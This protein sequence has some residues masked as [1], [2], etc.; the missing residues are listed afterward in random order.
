MAGW[1]DITVGD[2]GFEGRLCVTQRGEPQNISGFV[3]LEYEL[4]YAKTNT[5]KVVTAS[6]L[7]DGTDG[8]LTYT[9]LPG[10][11]DATG[12]WRVRSVISR[13]NERLTSDWII[14]E[15]MP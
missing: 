1:E 6:F 9:F 15:V 3:T 4:R 12:R 8:W 7:T 11:I 5:D 10:D 13:N 2:Y 14:F